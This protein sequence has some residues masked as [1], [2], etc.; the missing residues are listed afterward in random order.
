MRWEMIDK[1]F[2]LQLTEQFIEKIDTVIIRLVTVSIKI[3][4]GFVMYRRG[5]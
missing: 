4:M 3:I 1:R 5:G 2:L